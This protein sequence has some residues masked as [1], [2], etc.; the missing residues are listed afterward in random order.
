MESLSLNN[1]KTMYGIKIKKLPLGKYLELTKKV[2]ILFNDLFEKGFSNKSIE[3]ILESIININK[4][5]LINLFNGI[6]KIAPDLLIDFIVDVLEVD[7]NKF[8]NN[9]EIGLYE[10][11]EIIETFIEINNLGKLMPKLKKVISMVHMKIQNIG[12]KS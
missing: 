3:S 6:F 2:N 5:E 11:T 12:Y 9:N 1:S 7:K 8:I 4:E 10:L